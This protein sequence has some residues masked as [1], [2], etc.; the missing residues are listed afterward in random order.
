MFVEVLAVFV[1][2]VDRSDG[3]VLEVLD[4][5]GDLVIIKAQTF[6]NEETF[7]SEIKG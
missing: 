2:V 1:V 3:V 4:T 7:Y 6:F 5:F